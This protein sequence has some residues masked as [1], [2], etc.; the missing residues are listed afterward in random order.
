MS[1]TDPP[2]KGDEEGDLP[3]LRTFEE[4]NY[5]R[6]H[7]E[8]DE[9]GPF[10]VQGTILAVDVFDNSEAA[11]RLETPGSAI[12]EAEEKVGDVYANRLLSKSE[13]KSE[14]SETYEIIGIE[15]TG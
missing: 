7:L 9:R 3:R 5:V 2:S 15:Q 11:I 4:G 6:L 8:S 13:G 1:Q 10:S 12:W 14:W